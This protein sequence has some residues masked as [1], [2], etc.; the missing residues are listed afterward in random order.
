MSRVERPSWQRVQRRRGC[1][2]R[3][4][5]TSPRSTFVGRHTE[6][7]SA[8]P[9]RR[10]GRGSNRGVP[11]TAVKRG[12]G[13]R[14]SGAS[15]LFRKCLDHLADAGQFL[16]RSGLCRE[17]AHHEAL[18]RTVERPLHQVARDL[19]LGLLFGDTRLVDVRLK[20][21]GAEEQPLFGH[22]LHL[23]QRGGVADIF[24]KLFVDLAHGGWSKPPKN[25]EDVDFSGTGKGRIRT[26]AVGG[27]QSHL[28]RHYNDSKRMS[29][30]KIVG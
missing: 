7:R 6:R 13:S 12:D 25:G 10:S 20:T 28:L 15:F 9:A 21:L 22:Q 18:G 5:G 27:F 17:S 26:N 19:C 24:A 30:T 3:S 1:T 16:A 2:A 11:P 23:L 4:G 29:T 14:S 8:G